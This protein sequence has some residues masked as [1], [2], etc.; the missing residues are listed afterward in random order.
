MSADEAVRRLYDAWQNKGGDFSEVPL[1]E[2]FQFTAP[3]ASFDSAGGYR[4]MAREA[5]RAVTSFV[6][7]RRFVDGDSVRSSH[8]LRDG[9]SWRRQAQ[10]GRGARGGRRA[11]PARRALL[12]R[13]ATAACDGG[14]RLAIGA[15]VGG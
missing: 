15:R 8:R 9:D 7:R 14:M 6:I 10:C 4:A 3:V 5:G 13:R 11:D 2:D 1:A 12:R